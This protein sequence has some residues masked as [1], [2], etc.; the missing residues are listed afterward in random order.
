MNVLLLVDPYKELQS[1][2]FHGINL[3]RVYR[4]VNANTFFIYTMQMSDL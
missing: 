3:E 4:T 2:T 1:Q